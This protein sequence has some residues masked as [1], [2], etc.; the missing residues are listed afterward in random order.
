LS[1]SSGRVVAAT[2]ALG[3][4]EIVTLAY[5]VW[6]AILSCRHGSVGARTVSGRKDVAFGPSLL[7]TEVVYV[8]G[9]GTVFVQAPEGESREIGRG[10]KR[11][12]V[13]DP[14]GSVVAWF[15]QSG[16]LPELV[17]YDT[18]AGEELARED[19]GPAD[20]GD[21]RYRVATWSPIVAVTD[22]AVYYRGGDDALMG[23]RWAEVGYPADKRTTLD[24]ANGVTA[25][26][27][28]TI[29]FT[30]SGTDIV[31]ADEPLKPTGSLSC[32]IT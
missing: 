13:G 30:R 6:A 19:V 16:P 3:H 12:A 5:D 32:A 2:A 14:R 28:D 25:R 23:F 4:E 24:V 17:V 7:R 21:P 18:D 15:D 22:G 10:A 20:L 1:G 8:D 31:R 9:H 27:N 11:G 26:L 29:Y